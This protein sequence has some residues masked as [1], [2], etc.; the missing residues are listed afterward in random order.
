MGV[1]RPEDTTAIIDVAITGDIQ[2][3]AVVYIFVYGLCLALPYDAAQNLVLHF[4]ALVAVALALLEHDSVIEL[5]F[6]FLDNLLV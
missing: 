4:L 1:L 5:V 6:G 2:G 3:F